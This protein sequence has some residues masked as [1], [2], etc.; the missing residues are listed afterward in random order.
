MSV[1]F[2]LFKLALTLLDIRYVYGYEKLKHDGL[3]TGTGLIQNP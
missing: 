2:S 3:G 1:E